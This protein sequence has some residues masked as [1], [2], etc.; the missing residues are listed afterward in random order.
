M[1]PEYSRSRLKEWLLQG[2]VTVDD[3]SPRPRDPVHGGE[4]VVLMPPDT[5]I[6]TSEPEPI[7][8]DI[9]YEDN[10]LL[11]VN[12]PP[13]LVVHPGAGN[14]RGTL[15]NGL[16]AYDAG[17]R[18]LPRAGIVHRLDKETSGLLLVGRNIEAHTALVRA[19][20]EREIERRYIAVCSGV[21][22]G[23][24]KIDAPIARH[25][26]DRWRMAVVD[27]GKPAVTHYRVLERFRGH[28]LVDVRLETGRTHQ[29]RVHF[30][31]RRHPLLGD[32]VYGGRMALPRGASPALETVLREFGRQALHAAR[33]QFAQPKT[34]ADIEVSAELP[35]DLR[36]LLTVLREDASAGNVS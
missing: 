22:T 26:V 33:L 7:E 36:E 5:D 11:V 31:H 27:N 16:L 6:V 18:Q 30:A 25:P 17:L 2:Y 3:E 1:F 12:K 32:P 23:G 19:L 35:A 9:A 20:A 34:G 4:Q 8:L 10:D 15:M 21:L 14:P 24:G 28:T 29:I 13:G